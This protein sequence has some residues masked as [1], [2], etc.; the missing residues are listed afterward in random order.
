MPEVGEM[1]RHALAE[2]AAS[3]AAQQQVRGAHTPS[4]IIQLHA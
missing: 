2:V 3:L 4:V 1:Q